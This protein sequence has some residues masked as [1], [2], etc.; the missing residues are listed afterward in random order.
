MTNQA[1]N[2][3]KAQQSMTPDKPFFVY[4]ATGRDACA[5]PRAEGVGRQVQGPVRQGLGPGA[6]RNARA[7]E[8]AGHRPGRHASWAT[9]PKDLAAWDSLPAD[10]RRLFARQAEVFA[11]FL[12][13]TDAEIGRFRQALADIGELDNTL[14][15]YIAGDNGT[16]AEGGFVGMYNEM[17]YFNGVA[18]KVEDLIPLIDKWGRSGNLPA[19]GG[20][21]GRGLRH[22]LLV[23]QAGG[24][25]LRRHAQ[26]RGHPAG[27]KGIKDKGGLRTQFSHVIDIAP[28]ILEAAGLPEPKSVNGDGADADRRHEHGLRLQR[29]QGA[30]AAH[31]AVLR[32]VRQPRDLQRRLVRAHHPPRAVAD[33]RTAAADVRRLGALR[34]EERFQPHEEPGGRTGREAEGDAGPVHEGGRE[35][36]RAADRRPDDRAHQRGARGP[37][38][39]PGYPHLAH[40]LRG[41]AGDAGKHLHEHQEPVEQDH[42]GSGDPG[43]RAPTAPSCRRAGAS[44]GGRCT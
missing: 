7:A 11:G 35:V 37:A 32:D 12:E 26:R 43:R 15:I 24:V 20:R 36:P 10:Q 31:D 1:I 18:E 33:E 42:R 34:R 28:T 39:R 17:T 30:G 21:L 38:R 27:R 23:D 5:A 29:R 40:A 2:W 22:A 4:Y 16:S 6:R 14:F 13:Q 19:H 8:E 44:A 41:H 3:V 25:R 9:R